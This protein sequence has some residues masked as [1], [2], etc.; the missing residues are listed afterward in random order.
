M[1]WV[2]LVY[3]L[4]KTIPILDKAIRSLI[5]YY[6]ALEKKWFYDAVTK[7]M[8]DAV[9]GDQRKLEEAINSDRAGKPS[10]HSG[11]RWRD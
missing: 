1:T 11:T 8:L 9:G 2:S 6:A 7:G 4:I 5:I 3:S 10:G